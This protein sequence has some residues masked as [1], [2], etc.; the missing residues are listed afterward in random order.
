MLNNYFAAAFLSLVVVCVPWT[1]MAAAGLYQADIPKCDK[2]AAASLDEMY[3]Q[4]ACHRSLQIARVHAYAAAGRFPLNTDF[5]GQLVPYFVD[6]LGTACAIGHLMRL[7]GRE[8]LVNRIAT[9]CNHVRIADV[10]HGPLVDWI[11]NSGLTQEECA[12]IQP[13]YATIEDYRQGSQ[14]QNEVARLPSTLRRSRR[15]WRASRRRVWARRSL[16]RLKR[17]SIVIPPTQRSATVL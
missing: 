2:P 12:L 6:R 14:W 15:P 11:R 3:K 13:S 4:L 1:Q 8:Q 9:S 5:P 17:S 16:P 10:D 7:D